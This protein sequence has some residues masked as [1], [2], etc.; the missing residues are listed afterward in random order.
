MSILGLVMDG[1]ISRHFLGSKAV[2]FM[3]LEKTLF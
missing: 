1:F 2:F 3:F